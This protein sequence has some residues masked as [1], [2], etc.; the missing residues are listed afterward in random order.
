MT[1]LEFILSVMRGTACPKDADTAQQITFHTLRFEAAKAAAP[2][3]HPRL[4]QRDEPVKMEPLSGSLSDQAGRVLNSLVTGVLTPSQAASIM[5]T[6]AAQAKIVEAD[7]FERR[8]K[9]LEEH[10]NALARS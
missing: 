8:I 6:I 5:Q 2:Y 3:I 9:A 7:D 10:K 1:P 4:A